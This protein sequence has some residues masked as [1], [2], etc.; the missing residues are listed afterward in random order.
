MQHAKSGLRFGEERR[1][2]LHDARNLALSE[3]E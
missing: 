1:M 2:I 3:T